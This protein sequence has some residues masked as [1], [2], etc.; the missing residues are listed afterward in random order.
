MHGVPLAKTRWDW[1]QLLGSTASAQGMKEFGM[2]HQPLSLAAQKKLA[3]SV[4]IHP[5]NE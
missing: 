5:D 2:Q 4:V 1:A 3:K